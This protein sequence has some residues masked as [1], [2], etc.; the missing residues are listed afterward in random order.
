ML[1]KKIAC[2]SCSARLRVAEAVSAGKSLKCPKC[3]DR[4]PAPEDSDDTPPPQAATVKRKKK[5]H[6]APELAW[7]EA[8]EKRPIY[9][10]R[11]KIWKK[12]TGSTAIRW[13]VALIIVAIVIGAG[14]AILWILREHL[15]RD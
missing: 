15:P 4:F 10:T 11:R 13:G 3:G 9:Q 5:P 14:V 1:T 6:H 2:P 7:G 12:K 8:V